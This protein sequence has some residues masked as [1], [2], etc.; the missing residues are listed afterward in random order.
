MGD[1]SYRRYWAEK[2]RQTKLRGFSATFDGK[3]LKLFKDGNP[4]DD[5]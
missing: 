1:R 5:F 3:T 4:F 2:E